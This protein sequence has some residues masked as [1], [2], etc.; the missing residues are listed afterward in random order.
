MGA[1]SIDAEIE[2]A[3]PVANAAERSLERAL[4]STITRAA[5]VLTAA[6]VEGA[7]AHLLEQAA[8]APGAVERLV[9]LEARISVLEGR[10]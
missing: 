8:D 5:E 4:L 10:P 9:E 1:E 6:M 7:S 2:K 3:D